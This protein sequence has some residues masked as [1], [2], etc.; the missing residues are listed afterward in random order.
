METL[1][2]TLIGPLADLVGRWIP[3]P[4]KKAEVQL[5]MMR[6]AQAGELEQIKAA[7]QAATAQTDINRADASGSAMQR[8]WRPLIGWVCAGALAWD[9]IL[10]PVFIFVATASGHPLPPLPT[11]T[12]EQ[13]YSITFGLL[14]LGGFRTIEKIKGAV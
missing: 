14:G 7:I 2:T 11:L 6:L 10:K 5:E 13:I 4:Q 1:L 3:D 8:N 12:S 9:G